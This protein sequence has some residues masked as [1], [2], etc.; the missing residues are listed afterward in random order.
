MAENPVPIV[1]VSGT[2]KDEVQTTFHCLEVGALA[3]VP[4]PEGIGSP[5]YAETTANLIDTVKLMAEVRV[6]R[7]RGRPVTTPPESKAPVSCLEYAP[8]ST[9]LVAIGASAGGPQC[10]QK[11]LGELPAEFSLPVLLVQHMVADFVPGFAQWLGTGCGLTVKLAEAGELLKP[12]HVYVAPGSRQTG[13]DRGGR[14]QVADLPPENGHCPSVSYMFRS[15]TEA[16]G[17]DVIGILLTGMGADGAEELRLMRERGALT[18][19]QDRA[20]SLV[21]G[22]PGEAVRLGAACHVLPPAEIGALLKRVSAAVEWPRTQLC[23]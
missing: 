22:M 6:V 18:V 10:V 15:V 9:R 5:R 12:G 11:L 2:V 3:F 8:E 23:H 19:A 17:H 14:L 21:F 1:M 13:I 16:Y 4:R 7:R 20:S